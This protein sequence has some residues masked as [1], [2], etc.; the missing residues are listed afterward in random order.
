MVKEIE[1]E[2]G[3]KTLKIYRKWNLEK[4]IKLFDIDTRFLILI[5]LSFLRVF[6]FFFCILFYLNTS[7]AA[8][9]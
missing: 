9:R 6:F 1:S 7:R 3:N 8:V 5:Y 4:V 2:E